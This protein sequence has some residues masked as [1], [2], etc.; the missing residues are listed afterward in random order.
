MN[1]LYYKKTFIFYASLAPYLN[2][3]FSFLLFNNI[4]MTLESKASYI[5]SLAFFSSFIS[6]VFMC[7]LLYEIWISKEVIK[8]YFFTLLILF[9]HA[10][11]FFCL[12]C[13]YEELIYVLT[14]CL[15]TSGIS[16]LYICDLIAKNYDLDRSKKINL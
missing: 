6:I 2:L 15:G 14:T 7:Y 3:V 4:E 9:S 11:F 12:N 8:I 13:Y 5:I 16:A 10:L 1:I